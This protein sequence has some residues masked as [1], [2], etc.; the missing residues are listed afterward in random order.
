MADSELADLT[1]TT[2]LAT[3]DIFYVVRDPAGT[4]VDRKI[5]IDDLTATLQAR[6]GGAWTS[7]TPTWSSSGT[8]PSLGNGTIAGKYKYDAWTRMLHIRVNLSMGSTTT[9]GTGLYRFSIPSGFTV[10]AYEN[11]AVTGSMSDFS[12][13]AFAIC[14]GAGHTTNDLRDFITGTGGVLNNTTP[15]TWANGDT[16]D[17]VAHLE[18]TSP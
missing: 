6:D 5:T 12:A 16:L 15:W 8:A 18:A 9:Y 11:G 13:G 1:A 17:L 14:I 4:A 10:V 7:Y 3:G 2:T